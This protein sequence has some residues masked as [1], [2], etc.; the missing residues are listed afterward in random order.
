MLN[1]QVTIVGAGPAGCFLSILLARSG[2]KVTLLEQHTDFDREFRGNAFQPSVVRSLDEMGLG[3]LL[4]ELDHEKVDT[5]RI[6]DKQGELFTVPL[7]D[8]PAP[9]NYAVITP[10][11]P[12]LKRLVREACRYPNFRFIGGAQVRGLIQEAGQFT[13]VVAE[14]DG[15][16]T[17]IASQLI[18]GAD[19][20]YSAVRRDAGIPLKQ[21]AQEFDFVWFVLPRV[22]KNQHHLGLSLGDHGILI[23]LPKEKDTSQIGWLLPKGRFAQLKQE[24]LKKFYE[25]VKAVDPELGQVLPDHLTDFNKLSVL[26]VQ[27]GHAETWCRD[28]LLLIGD[29]AHIA[30]PIGAQGNKL[31]IED[32]VCVHPLIVQALRDSKNVAGAE[33]FRSYTTARR[34]AVLRILSLQ[35]LQ[36]RILFGP[37]KWHGLRN[38]ALR[39]LN[40]TPLR[41]KLAKVFGL[42]QKPVLVDKT[43]FDDTSNE[44]PARV[45]H[46]LKV[47]QVIQETRQA[48]SYVFEAPEDL[49]TLFQYRAGQFL[50]VRILDKGRLLKR[51]YSFSSAPNV[52]AAMTVTIKHIPNGRV[53]GYFK[54]SVHEGDVL[55]VLPPA[56]GFVHTPQTDMPKHYV[57]FAAGSGITPIYSILKSV[58][59]SEPESR[60]TLIYGNHDEPS[61]IFQKELDAMAAQHPDRFS[62]THVLERLNP[63]SV[64]RF[65]D[66][67]AEAG[68]AHREYFLCGPE[69]MMELVQK[70]LRK[71]QVD[72]LH[73]HYEKFVSLQGEGELHAAGSAT[74]EVL[75]V[76]ESQSTEEEIPETVAVKINGKTTALPCR[77]DE[78]ILDAA[79]RAGLNPPFSCQSGVCATCTA[80]LVSG[81]VRMDVHDALTTQD[82]ERR[83]ILTCQAVLLTREAKVNFDIL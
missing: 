11:P 78:T 43:F 54:K 39:F 19:G 14:I 1:T 71:K 7:G 76:G 75:E 26:D 67:A 24:G 80:K 27:I 22:T 56:G 36:G 2:V 30:S 77:K 45:Y 44:N 62:L 74:T 40:R 29:A 63:E 69:G 79:I 20:R 10:Q 15:T 41:K 48:S 8:L 9:Y 18:V 60:T 4:V 51:C 59:N 42:G 73:V 32:A 6:R 46:P 68:P 23:N 33:R 38:M 65:L 5:F 37:K 55:M 49:K 70:E 13:G 64:V 34:D 25:Q 82:I 50:T 3:S 21:T 31:A 57:L 58:L 35:N 47:T 12:L 72:G 83:N 17:I 61:I 16:R 66:A 53:S 52:D 28:G 81:K